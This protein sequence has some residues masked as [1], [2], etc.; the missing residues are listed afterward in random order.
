MMPKPNG[1]QFKF[2][3]TPQS[4]PAS[5]VARSKLLP[6][7]WNDSVPLPCDQHFLLDT[8]IY[9][10]LACQSEEVGK[11]IATVLDGHEYNS[12]I[13]DEVGR[14]D[15][16][17]PLASCRWIKKHMTDAN[18]AACHRTNNDSKVR[19][20]VTK[21]RNE[22]I[23]DAQARAIAR[24]VDPTSVSTN[25]EK[26]KHGGEA[27]LIW[28]ANRHEPKAYILTDDGGASAVARVHE[29]ATG[30]FLH[31]LRQAVRDEAI[32]LTVALEASSIVQ[33][34]GYGVPPTA[35]ITRTDSE[36]WLSS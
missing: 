7:G 24:G 22:L 21:V 33:D 32:T 4:R 3:R 30:H 14:P 1:T 20:E 26:A 17:S 25:T 9:H 23:A 28:Q 11:A 35:E 34:S 36:E 16:I 13:A 10:N 6:P 8:G 29:V 2:A 15:P 19:D 18:T 31:V 5:A 27:E 12:T